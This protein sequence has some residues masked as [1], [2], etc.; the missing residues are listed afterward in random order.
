MN[1]AVIKTGGKQ[2]L[3]R[4]GQELEVEKLALDVGGK[5][6]FDPLCIFDESGAS[7]AVGTP[8]IKGASV[9]AIVVEQGKDDK[10]EVIKF[11]PKSR[12]RRV[13][14]HRQP[15]TKIRIEAIKA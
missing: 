12:Y 11:K 13:R 6:S 4:Q 9:S 1:I 15:Y 7:I 3:V 10:V 8:T 5:I 14:G 2:Y